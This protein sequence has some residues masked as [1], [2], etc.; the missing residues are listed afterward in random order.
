MDLKKITENLFEPAYLVDENRKIV[1]WNNECEKVTGYL[2][3]EVTGNYCYDNI[4]R[5]ITD[6]GKQLCHDGCPL[7]ESIKSGKINSADVYLHHKEGYRIPVRVK[8]IPVT[9]NDGK[10]SMALEVFTDKRDEDTLYRENRKLKMKMLTDPLTKLY[11]RR[12]MDYQ[13]KMAFNE[14]Q[15]FKTNPG[16]IFMDIDDFKNVNDTYGHETGDKVLKALANTIR[17]N[18]RQ[19]DFPGRFGGEEFI[20]LIRD[21]SKDEILQIAEK[22]RKLI[23]MLTITTKNEEILNITVSA[24]CA[25]MN[26]K[27]NPQTLIDEADKNMYTAKKQG[28]NKVV[29]S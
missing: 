9:D 13:I 16:I 23:E 28:K 14:A 29:I 22:L 27:D 5:H 2:A 8:T 19:S 3:S 11:N 15:V 1:A 17:H 21:T 10:I 25:I 7:Q 4:L 20:V 24:G 12:F 26:E 18:V 6:N